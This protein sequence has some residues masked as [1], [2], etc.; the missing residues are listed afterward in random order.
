MIAV[1]MRDY[2]IV[3]LSDSSQLCG[4]NNSVGVSPLESRPAGVDEHRLARR[5]YEE[6]RLTTLNVN[7]VNLEGSGCCLRN[8]TQNK[9]KQ[10]ENHGLIGNSHTYAQVAQVET[11]SAASTGSSPSQRSTA[12]YLQHPS[13]SAEFRRESPSCLRPKAA[14]FLRPQS[15]LHAARPDW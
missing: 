10:K 5:A 13:S 15:N 11:Q 7:R 14:V 2:Q 9:E 3:N 4:C 6:R 12:D 8:N 1:I